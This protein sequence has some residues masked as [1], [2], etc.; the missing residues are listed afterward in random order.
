MKANKRHFRKTKVERIADSRSALHEMLKHVLQVEGKK[1]YHMEI[2]I[3]IKKE[4]AM[5]M[6]HR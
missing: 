6:V 1:R 4:R 2:G 3:Y 5:G